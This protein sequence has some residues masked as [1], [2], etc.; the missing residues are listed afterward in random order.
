MEGC[1]QK[2]VGIDPESGSSNFGVCITKL[3]DGLMNV[4]HAEEYARP[5]FNA[6]IQTTVKLLDEY[7]IRFGTQCRIFVDGANPSS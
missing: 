7:D 5:D 4:I 3:V 2:S 1:T 6:M